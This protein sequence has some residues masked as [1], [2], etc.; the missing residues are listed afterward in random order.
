MSS[1]GKRE[2]GLKKVRA[3]RKT[4]VTYL[5][6]LMYQ[7]L[8]PLWELFM[9]WSLICW[10]LL[11]IALL[12][13]FVL[14]DMYWLLEAVRKR[15]SHLHASV[16]SSVKNQTKLQSKCWQYVFFQSTNMLKLSIS[17][18]SDTDNAVL[19]LWLV[20]IRKRSGFGL[21]HLCRSHKHGWRNWRLIVNISCLSQPE[22]AAERFRLAAGK[23]ES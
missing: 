3:I 2:S 8:H 21:K 14:N 1:G 20:R 22:M 4:Q 12:Q 16:Y 23:Q 10:R 11:L 9:C 6:S 17:L 18:G 5:H 15:A 19:K 7:I 13:E